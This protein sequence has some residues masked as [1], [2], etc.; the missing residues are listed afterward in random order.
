MGRCSRAGS[1]VCGEGGKKTE[2]SASRDLLYGNTIT[3][4]RASTSHLP[5]PPLPSFAIPPRLLPSFCLRFALFLLLLECAFRF[6]DLQSLFF[7]F[8]PLTLLPKWP[9]RMVGRHLPR[10]WRPSRPCKGMCLGPK[11]PRPMNSLRSSRSRY[12]FSFMV[13]GF[14]LRVQA[15]LTCF[16]C[17]PTL[18]RGLDD[19]AR[20][21]TIFRC[22]RGS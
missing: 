9:A 21:I 19:Y 12:V 15:L 13:G 17:C 6:L 18:G 2:S 7:L 11:R 10:S 20:S 14:A 4:S 3:Q 8:K 5:L 16:R 1:R 22:P